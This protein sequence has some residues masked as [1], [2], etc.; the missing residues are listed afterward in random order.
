MH[1]GGSEGGLGG[2]LTSFL[3]DFSNNIPGE[4]CT[5]GR[6]HL[7]HW[8]VSLC[9]I[10]TSCLPCRIALTRARPSSAFALTTHPGLTAGID[11]LLSFAELMKHV[12][13]MDFDV[14]VFDTAPT[15]HTLRLLSLPD[16]VDKVGGGP[17][18]VRPM[19]T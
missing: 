12:Q 18:V 9:D 7:A 6:A 4:Y 19:A 15:G 1:A 17:P 10:A 13:R 3:K 14:T 11:E 5:A 16:M 2:G 8:H